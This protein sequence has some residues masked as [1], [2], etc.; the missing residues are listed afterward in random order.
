MRDALDTARPEFLVEFGVDS[1][2][3]GAHGFRSELDNGLDGVR[4]SLL[5]RSSVD[6]LMEVDGVFPRHDILE[7]R[8]S[9]A[10]LCRSLSVYPEPTQL[11]PTPDLFGFIWRDLRTSFERT[12]RD[13][14]AE[15]QHTIFFDTPQDRMAFVVRRR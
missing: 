9:L 1:D 13:S 5:E 12:K 3:G 14:E 4:S 8:A 11:G 2:V 6:A 7:S 15:N 10:S